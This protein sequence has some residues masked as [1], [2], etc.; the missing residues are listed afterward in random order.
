MLKNITLM[1]LSMILLTPSLAHA[2]DEPTFNLSVKGGNFI[3]NKIEVP[4]NQKVK[5]IVKNEDTVQAEFESYPLDRE[6]KISAGETTEVFVG[7]LS[8]GEYPF[9]DDNN[10]DAKGVLVAK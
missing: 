5:L 2:S 4:A 6:Q 3:P 7:P 10:P 9:F 8:S 1:G